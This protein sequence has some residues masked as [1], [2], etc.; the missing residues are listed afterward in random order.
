MWHMIG[1]HASFGKEYQ[2]RFVWGHTNSV[3]V[4]ERSL[5]IPT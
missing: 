4:C 3:Y 1:A 5:L 2:S